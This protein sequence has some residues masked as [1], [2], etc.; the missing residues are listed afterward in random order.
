MVGRASTERLN[1][2]AENFELTFNVF[3]DDLS[4]IRRGNGVVTN[5]NPDFRAYQYNSITDNY[6]P[7]DYPFV[8]EHNWLVAN[9]EAYGVDDPEDVYLHYAEDTVVTLQ[10]TAFTVP[11]WPNGSAQSREEARIPVYYSNPNTPRRVSAFHTPELRALWRAYHVSLFQTTLP[12]SNGEY[13]SGFMFD[14]ASYRSLQTG[15]Q[16]PRY[17]DTGPVDEADGLFANSTDFYNWYYYQ[18]FGLFEQELR[19]WALTNPPELQG[20]QLGIMP[21]IAEIPFATDDAWNDAYVDFHP[22]DI[23]IKEFQHSPVRYPGRTLPADVFQKNRDA[24]AAGID[25]LET[26]NITTSVFGRQGSFTTDEA[27][28]NML[29]Q[30]WVMRTPNIILW[31]YPAGVHTAAWD[32]NMRA[33][34]NTDI[35]QPLEDPQVLTTGT[36]GRGYPYTVY[37]RR[38]ACGLAIVRERGVYNEEFDD[39]TAV[40]VDLPDTYFPLDVDGNTP[41]TAVDQATLRNGQALLFL[42][43]STT[44]PPCTPDWRCTDWNQC[45]TGTQTRTCTDQN[46]CGTEQGR[47]AESQSCACQENWSCS[48]WSVC[49]SGEQMRTCTD[50]N[51]CGT[52]DLRPVLSQ[53]CDSTPPAAVTDLRAETNL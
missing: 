20:R 3:G 18:G 16:D 41:V 22:G 38:F 8:D 35:G 19:E 39:A 33:I 46:S 34:F 37:R 15:L 43:Q 28:M 1:Y 10:G 31:G 5:P 32:N 26:G 9:A 42:A 30:F 27:I 4:D 49:T 25:I 14:N 21:N 23:L 52:T 24:Q 53:S 51:A 17:G 45:T 47:P 13:W 7:P 6:V 29:G 11:G 36:D 48:A 44:P 2:I 40:T 12:L 50:A